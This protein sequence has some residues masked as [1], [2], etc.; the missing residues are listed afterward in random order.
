MP[1]I[2]TP[3]TEEGD[4]NVTIVD[5]VPDRPWICDLLPDNVVWLVKENQPAIVVLSMIMLEDMPG[6]FRLHMQ[7]GVTGQILPWDMCL[8]GRGID[9]SQLI[10]PCNN[11]VPS[12]ADVIDGTPI[13]DAVHHMYDV[14]A[15]MWEQMYDKPFPGFQHGQIPDVADAA[16][17]RNI[18]RSQF[19]SDLCMPKPGKKTLPQIVRERLSPLDTRETPEANKQSHPDLP[20][21]YEAAAADMNTTRDLPVPDRFLTEETVP[22]NGYPSGNRGAMSDEDAGAYRAG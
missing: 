2:T 4:L 22:T 13:I 21:P 20:V 1:K 18:R 5:P 9:G 19:R 17:S 10:A 16:L 7:H 8:H 11:W 15:Y 3:L 6:I 14:M 12:N